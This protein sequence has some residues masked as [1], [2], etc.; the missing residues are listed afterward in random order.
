[1]VMVAV[2]ARHPASTLRR[3]VDDGD[4]SLLFEKEKK[5]DGLNDDDALEDVLCGF[6]FDT[7]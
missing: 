5:D 4:G 2:S 1:M 3:V 7:T 6:C